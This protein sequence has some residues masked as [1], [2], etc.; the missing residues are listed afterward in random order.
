MITELLNNNLLQTSAGVNINISKIRDTGLFLAKINIDAGDSDP[1]L[2]HHGAVSTLYVTGNAVEVDNFLQDKLPEWGDEVST[3]HTS[4]EASLKNSKACRPAP[5]KKATPKKE[6]E[7]VTIEPDAQAIAKA[8]KLDLHDLMAKRAIIPTKA[9]KVSARIV[10]AYIGEQNRAKMVEE[11]NKKL[12]G[13][14]T[15]KPRWASLPF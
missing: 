6:K 10:N 1:A 3:S 8:N 11:D 13:V 14:D 12:E 15:D 9:G 5:K 2:M 4:I 7:A